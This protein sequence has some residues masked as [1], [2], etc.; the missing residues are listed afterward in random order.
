MI[1][2][3]SS[4]WA[5][6]STKNYSVQQK[7][8]MPTTRR[9]PEVA[10]QA[11]PAQT[12]VAAPPLNATAPSPTPPMAAAQARRSQN[13]PASS[14]TRQDQLRKLTVG[15]DISLSGEITT[16]DHLVV[17]GTVKATIKG[18]KVLEISDSGAFSGVVDIQDADI[19]GEFDGNLTVR[20]KLIIRSTATV[21]GKIAYARLQVDT[22][23]TINGE[24]STLAI[25]SAQHPA[26]QTPVSSDSEI[27]NSVA[28]N[29]DQARLFSFTAINDEPGFLKA[30]A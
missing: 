24:M 11:Y 3:K 5:T 20:G 12:T 25:K 1:F 21:T 10:R 29:D 16:C 13:S 22:G 8:S 28:S 14:F 23:A 6:S 7:A 2:K 27:E 15:R 19:A 9:E 4:D 26:I 17:E 18:G 30:S